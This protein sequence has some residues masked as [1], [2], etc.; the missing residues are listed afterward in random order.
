MSATE[1]AFTSAVASIT[2]STPFGWVA[3]GIV[4]VVS[5]CGTIAF[6]AHQVGKT[7]R[8]RIKRDRRLD[9]RH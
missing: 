2:F 5:V 1:L 3:L 6:V 7:E 8:A 9:K 4:G